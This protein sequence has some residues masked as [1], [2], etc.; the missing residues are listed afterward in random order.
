M[1]ATGRFQCWATEVVLLVQVASVGRVPF[2][3]AVV[4]PV[5]QVP[6]RTLTSAPSVPARQSSPTLEL[7]P[8]SSTCVPLA[9]RQ[10]PSTRIEPSWTAVPARLHL[11]WQD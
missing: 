6:Y 8:Y 4:G 2:A 10:T 7:Q 9:V 11:P 1:G 5:R 3:T